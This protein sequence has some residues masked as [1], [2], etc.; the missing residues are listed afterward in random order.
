MAI[1]SASQ[2]Q[3]F[4]RRAGSI[5]SQSSYAAS[6]IK[7]QN[8]AEDDY[9][10]NQYDT[11]NIT[12]EQYLNL[13]KA[14]QSNRPYYTPLQLQNLEQKITSV[15]ED[16]DESEVDRLYKEGQINTD[17]YREY[18][19]EKLD[20]L[21]PDNKKY[22]TMSIKVKGLEEKAQKEARNE[23]RLDQLLKI[24][25]MPG[26]RSAD[27]EKKAS[28]YEELENQAR[29]DG[30]ASQA[31]QFAIQKNN[32]RESA[33]KANINDFITET[34]LNV[35]ENYGPDNVGSPTA[36]S[37]ASL[38]SQ[39]NQGTASAGVKQ[40]GFTTSGASSKAVL[41]KMQR[42]AELQNTGDKLDYQIGRYQEAI[43]NA[44][45]D[46]RTTLTIALNNLI[47]SKAS[48]DQNLADAQQGLAEAQASAVVSQNKKMASS[49][50]RYFEQVEKELENGFRKGKIS[51]DD[52]ISGAVELAKMKDVFFQ[53]AT[54]AFDQLG[55]SDKAE[56]YL[57]KKKEFEDVVSNLERIS[58][59]R[60]N[61][62]PI[63]VDRDGKLTNVFGSGVAKGDVVLQDVSTMKDQGT[64]DANYA[65]VGG[66]YHR[67]YSPGSTGNDGEPLTFNMSEALAKTNE[68]QFVY[69]PG[70]KKINVVMARTVDP[71]TKKLKESGRYYTKDVIDRLRKTEKLTGAGV[72]DERSGGSPIINTVSPSGEGAGAKQFGG[73]FVD[74]RSGIIPQKIA[75][76][77]SNLR[78]GKA[79]QG[80]KAESGGVL[81]SIVKPVY[82]SDVKESSKP[83][84]GPKLNSEMEFERLIAD[85]LREQG[86]LTPNTL[87]YAMATAKH[88]ANFQPKSEIM[89]PV[90][91][92]AHND[93]IARLQNKYSGGKKYIGRGYVQLTH[94]YNYKEIGDAI[95]QDLVNNP[96][97][98]LKPEIAAKAMAAFF[99][100][101]G[102]ADYANKGDFVGARKPVNGTDKAREI[103]ATA[104]GY[105]PK[106]QEAVKRFSMPKAKA[107]R[108]AKVT[109]T[110][111]PK[112]QGILESIVE[113]VSGVIA[114][115]VS[116]AT[117]RSTKAP[118]KKQTGINVNP[119]SKDFLKPQT[120]VTKTPTPIVKKAIS[121]PIK[122][123]ATSASTGKP[124]VAKAPVLKQ[125]KQQSTAL[126][127]A[128]VSV[129]TAKPKPQAPKK[130]N[131]VQKT[132]S[133]A[134]SVLS[135]F[136]KKK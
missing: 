67:V 37:S 3:S 57:T 25:K 119:V 36:G 130:Q 125:T 93:R 107:I 85:A 52:Y 105:L 95:G 15:S 78:S 22:N 6:L 55:E 59:S 133:K 8:S 124:V 23:Y 46:Q 129:P 98:M 65:N 86:I 29:L 44:T 26:D 28:M 32:A 42:I 2:Y 134:K 45:G 114:P 122:A 31:D 1:R 60:E 54:D 34:S 19:K 118:S 79:K 110:P 68:N 99:K 51:K 43:A 113:G 17:Q 100:L 62:E 64:F 87:A 111:T 136:L 35:S 112:K 21:T 33:R 14:R 63:R 47:N 82:A 72:L 75:G 38:R 16:F 66:V 56:S 11:G 10:D 20:T 73:L 81:S 84:Y 48:N 120:R 9:W 74:P 117:L 104:Q 102:V 27:L 41:N 92:D 132:V 50:E 24:S 108:S 80:K 7:K 61:W 76:V 5:G 127:K 94:D 135:G 89:A 131:I 101:R 49:Q 4:R 58:E 88:E 109:P 115:P 123:N 12:A 126:P 53:D 71:K 128:K 90:G 121:T 39:G 30:D 77:I 40:S 18:F 91:K 69:G 116:G 96:E 70:G 13:L 103:A 106:S 83:V 97:L